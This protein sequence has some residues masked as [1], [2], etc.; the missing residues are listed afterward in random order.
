MA[1]ATLC[2]GAV[3]KGEEKED[4]RSYLTIIKKLSGLSAT[5]VPNYF[6]Y[7]FNIM[8]VKHG[9]GWS[10]LHYEIAVCIFVGFY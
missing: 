9:K 4:N 6:L 1:N 10:K 7:N 8:V 2:K 5:F 3:R